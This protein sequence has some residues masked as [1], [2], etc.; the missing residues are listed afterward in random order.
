MRK[1]LP[2]KATRVKFREGRA[3]RWPE[4]KEGRKTLERQWI[5]MWL[6]LLRRFYIRENVGS[7]INP[8]QNYLK[9]YCLQKTVINLTDSQKG[10]FKLQGFAALSSYA[11]HLQIGRSTETNS[12]LIQWHVEPF[13]SLNCIFFFLPLFLSF[14]SMVWPGCG[15]RVYLGMLTSRSKCFPDLCL[16]VHLQSKPFLCLKAKLYQRTSERHL[17]QSPTYSFHLAKTAL[18]ATVCHGLSPK[19]KQCFM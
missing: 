7:K 1:R 14:Y 17:T 18:T 11:N 2:N 12:K 16:P 8:I 9:M 6:H 5:E 13:P 15:P 3:N 19:T 4:K 10:L